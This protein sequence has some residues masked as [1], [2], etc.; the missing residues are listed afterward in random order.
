MGVNPGVTDCRDA[1]LKLTAVL[2][3]SRY[4]KNSLYCLFTDF[5]GVFTSLPLGLIVKTIDIL[6]I[7]PILRKMWK[8]IALGNQV[9]L[10]VNG[11]AFETITI[12]RGIAQGKTINPLTF[13]VVK[14]T[15]AKWIERECRG[16]EIA[17]I[18]VKGMDYMDYMD[19]EV[20]IADTEE[21]IRKMATIQSQ[22]AEWSGM[23]LA[24][25]SA[26]TGPESSYEGEN[27]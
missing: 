10:I 12:T 16:Y 21:K 18:E 27:T 15:V 23:H 11:Q 25:T 6:P 3:D 20:C 26:H 4:M 22:F 19:D 9:G 8:E 17:G 5:K 14:E 2:E 13:A 24:F 1:N 7:C